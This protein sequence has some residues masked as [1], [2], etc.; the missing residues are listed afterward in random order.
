LQEDSEQLLLA[1]KPCTWT[2][3]DNLL[4]MGGTCRCG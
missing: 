4:K 3:G 1:D 2:F